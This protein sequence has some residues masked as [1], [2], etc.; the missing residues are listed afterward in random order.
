ML[1]FAMTLSAA[2]AV[3]ADT[4]TVAGS[5]GMIPLLT[6]LGDAYMK[7]HPRDT[8]KV[9]KSSITQSGGVL[10]ARSGAVDIGMSARPVAMHEMDDSVAAYHIADVAATVAVHKNVRVANLSS[11]QLCAIYSGR[12]TNWRE[13]GGHDA[14]IIVLTRP[15][16]DSTK[17]TLRDGIG[18]FKGLQETVKAQKMFKSNDMLTALQRLPDTIGIIDVIALEQAQGNAHP[19]R[20]DAMSPSAKEIAAGRWP[21]VK[22]YT[23]IIRKERKKGVDRFMHFIRSREGAALIARH[24]GVPVAFS[25]P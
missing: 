20:L 18:C 11:Q 6:M 10:A 1:A 16:S 21:V 5:G 12:I 17:M 22:H 23:L 2:A 13:V 9:S 8:I 25:Y 4:V 7:K 24:K 15:E 3:R 19:V 14:P